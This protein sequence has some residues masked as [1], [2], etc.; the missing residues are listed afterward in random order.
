MITRP[1]GQHSQSEDFVP[2][3]NYPAANTAAV[4][5]LAAKENLKNVIH[6]IQWSY[7]AAP[8]GGRLFITFGGVT[9]FDVDI[10]AAGPGGFDFYLPGIVNEAVVITLA[11][12]GAAIVGKLNAQAD[13]TAD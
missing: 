7:S 3:F 6:Y 12:G 13:L 1:V 9:K 8:T 2:K 10:T 5:T 4:I 11:A